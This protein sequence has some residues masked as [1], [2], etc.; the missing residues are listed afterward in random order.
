MR[1]AFV[2]GATGFVGT[3]LVQLLRSQDWQVH[4]LVR[5]PAK[6]APLSE[7]GAQLHSGS[8][9]DAASLAAALTD[10]DV[11]FH[12]AG[13]VAAL[14]RSEFWEDN[15]EGTRR[16][17][18][19]CAGCAQPPTVVQVSSLAAAGPSTP[20]TPRRE[21]DT[22]APVSHY[23]QSKLAAEQVAVEFADRVPL[24][25]V[26][27]PVVF[28][29]GDRNSL[30]LFTSVRS[31]HLHILPGF[32]EMP[33]SLVHVADLCAALLLV[34][35]GGRRVAPPEKADGV[36]Y[37]TSGPAVTYRRFGELAARSQNCRVLVLPAPKT[38]FWI[39]GAL[40]EGL[41][42]LQGRVGIF[43]LDKIREAVASGWQC[44]DE[45]LRSELG[46]NHAAT[47]ENR[48]AETV[49]WYRRHGWL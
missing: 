2:T 38:I 1:R 49:D 40:A 28:G 39:A 46:Y 9:Q 29:E 33:M 13:R 45:K 41:G 43:N 20:G 37:V 23:G 5:N 47:L 30:T 24:S 8:L 17:L 48:F 7:C 22:E 15:V 10:V 26:R 35:E 19:T 3:N 4:C 16:L 12:V 25:I 44:S 31:S 6:A 32:R 14:R 42:Q 27:P 21:T 11:V 18:A 36:Y 34:A